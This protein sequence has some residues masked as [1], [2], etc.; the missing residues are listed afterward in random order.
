[1]MGLVFQ[2][3][4]LSFFLAKMDVLKAEFMKS[5]RRHAFV[6]IGVVSAV[7]TPPDLFTCL[8]VMIPMYGLY[9][10]SIFIVSK[11]NDNVRKPA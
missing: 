3:P 8:M 10:F 5:Y 1:M 6:L 4:V 11:T 9:E 7:I 2:L